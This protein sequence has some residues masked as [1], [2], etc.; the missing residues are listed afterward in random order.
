MLL[1]A[2]VN[3][4]SN[5]DIDAAARSVVRIVVVGED[6][7][8][9]QNVGMGSGVAITR[10]RI[11]TNAHV[12]EAAVERGGFVGVVPSEGG[13]RYTGRI[14]AYAPEL[15]L[16]VVALEGGTIPPAV[17]FNGLVTDG[18]AVAA[19]GYPY[20]VDRA[21]A[22]GMTEVIRPQSPVKS[23]GNVGGRRSN[24]RFDTVLHDAAIGRGNSGGPLVDS[25][26]RVIGINSFLSISEGID[27][28][29]AFALSVK[30]LV[31]F[32]ARAKV[33]PTVTA[34]PCLSTAELAEREAALD[35]SD[36]EAAAREQQRA[37][38]EQ[39]K[40]S[41]LKLRIR[42]D[43]A[44]ERDNALAL[45]VLIFGCGTVGAVGGLVMLGKRRVAPVLLGLSGLLALGA[46][47]VF[48]GRPK[49]SAVEDR[50]AAMQPAKPASQPIAAPQGGEQMCVINS[51][52]SRVTV[53]KADDVPLS[54]AETGCVNGTT[55]YGSNAGIWS[56]TFVPNG[57]PTVTI[58]SYD[59]AKARYTVERFLMAADA[60]D[61][62]RAIRGRY[63]NTACTADP[64]Q[65]RSV[66]EMETAIRAVLPPTPNE[67]LVYDCR[68]AP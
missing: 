46:V 29:F 57:E 45:A 30:E 25:C 42:D 53:S 37:E 33:S 21:M 34:A 28:T 9:E 27:S 47:F 35:R 66:A 52:R 48:L 40:A 4:Q 63:K 1:P 38:T 2:I 22:S 67:R 54:W 18:T 44:D 14:V 17:L 15:D 64:G 13:K 50:F 26:G 56:R 36:E 19:L 65:R 3:A 59:P 6:A 20:G 58:Q 60:M 24:D 55:Q 68:A 41:T 43:I 51:E 10:N 5:P 23:L 62:A 12:V 16:A 8:G 31:A 39:S 49:F 61:K 32:L 7:A 11:V